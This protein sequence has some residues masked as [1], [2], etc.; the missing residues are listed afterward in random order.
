[1]IFRFLHRLFLQK[2]CRSSCKASSCDSEGTLPNIS[3]EFLIGFLRNYFKDYSRHSFSRFFC[4]NTP[5]EISKRTLRT[6]AGETLAKI[7]EETSAS[8]PDDVSGRISY[9]SVRNFLR[10]LLESIGRPS[11]GVKISISGGRSG[12]NSEECVV[13][14]LEEHSFT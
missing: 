10:K 13:D 11:T 5:R 6:A 2:F 1:M 7:L 3:P 9:K 8:I 4:K 14:F 12:R